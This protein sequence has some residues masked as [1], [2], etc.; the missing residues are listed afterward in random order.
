MEKVTAPEEKVL[1]IDNDKETFTLCKKVLSKEGYKVEHAL[2]G[3]SALKMLSKESYGLVLMEIVMPD[4]D[5]VEILDNIKKNHE[6]MAVVIISGQKTIEKAVEAMR[7]GAH[8]YITKPFNCEELKILVKRCF[9]YKRLSS[10][11]HGLHIIKKLY[12]AIIAISS[13]MNVD[14][15]YHLILEFACGIVRGDS[16]TIMILNEKTQQLEVKV[17]FALKSD[18]VRARTVRVGES[19]SG[20]VVKNDKP[21]LLIGEVRDD[22]RFTDVVL[23]P[24][25]K[26]SLC[27]PLKIKDKVVGA[28]NVNTTTS[29]HVFNKSDLELLKLFAE[30][31]GV[32]IENARQV[33]GRLEELDKIKTEFI[34][35]VS[36]E[37]RTPL[38]VINWT[39]K[40]LVD[41]VFG[42]LDDKYAKWVK[43]IGKN[44][45][46]LI[47]LIN[48]LLDLSKLENGKAEILKSN[49]NVNDIIETTVQKLSV[50]AVEK[51]IEMDYT[52]KKN[53]LIAYANT[54]RIEQV[55]NNLIMNAIKFTENEG[56]VNITSTLEDN[57][58]KITVTD[59]GV[60][61][62]KENLEVVF[63]KFRQVKKDEFE[64]NRGLG[65]GLSIAKEIILQ[66]QGSIWAEQNKPKG[67]RFL[68]TLPA[69]LVET[70]K[71]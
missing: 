63:D 31:A 30:D 71:N 12:R 51:N 6:D 67:S 54:E 20:W 65:I 45:D 11:I 61:L 53:P 15:V 14:R 36:H 13:L 32:A 52:V 2:N 19:V 59:T 44:S 34:A 25:I 69:V 62:A 55:I 68:F 40:N 33:Y 47:T 18:I 56:K 5:G 70:R 28:I 17:E 9:E 4:I 60:G 41:G 46:Q 48:N 50:L 42:D 64:I 23:R 1:I 24:E 26:S 16:G 3:A 35:T 39:V 21:L 10:E 8:D 43:E 66:H 49:I 58:V 22:K 38:T 7:K 27:V 57:L 37:L 29:P